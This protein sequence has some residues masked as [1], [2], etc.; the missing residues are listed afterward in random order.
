M[1]LIIIKPHFGFLYHFATNFKLSV[2][3]VFLLMPT[4]KKRVFKYYSIDR[5]SKEMILLKI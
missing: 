5:Q 4:A 2:N 1:L 3:N